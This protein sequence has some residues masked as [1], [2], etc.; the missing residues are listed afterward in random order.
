MHG[1]DE[2]VKAEWENLIK[3]KEHLEDIGVDRII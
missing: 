1:R 3:G 2:R